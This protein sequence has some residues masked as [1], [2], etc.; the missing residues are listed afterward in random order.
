MR[1]GFNRKALL[2]SGTD[3]V[4][5][6]V[7]NNCQSAIVQCQESN[8]GVGQATNPLNQMVLLTLKLL[9]L[10]RSWAGRPDRANKT[11]REDAK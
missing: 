5:G 8:V 7:S 1:T 11:L 6:R 9:R 3:L 10:L 4:E 2:G